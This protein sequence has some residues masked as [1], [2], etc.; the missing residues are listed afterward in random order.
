LLIERVR[1]QGYQ[2]V[3]VRPVLKISFLRDDQFAIAI[4]AL[5]QPGSKGAP[6]SAR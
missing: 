3:A 5:S 6:R 1:A 4:G 2:P